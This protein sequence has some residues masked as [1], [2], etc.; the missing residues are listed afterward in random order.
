[1]TPLEKILEAEFED[2]LTK[3][4][5]L[6]AELANRPVVWAIQH[7]ETKTLAERGGTSVFVRFSYGARL[8][9]SLDLYR[10][11]EEATEAIPRDF[12]EPEHWQVV[13]YAGRPI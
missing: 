7:I 11:R 12:F 13:P 5:E 9:A 6:E 4:A 1:M 2:L 3:I 10:S 8:P